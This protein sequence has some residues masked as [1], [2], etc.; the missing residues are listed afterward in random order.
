MQPP[1]EPLDKRFAFENQKRAERA[2]KG[3]DAQTNRTTCPTTTGAGVSQQRIGAANSNPESE[4]AED[5]GK[6]A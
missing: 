5:T 6:A 1:Q 3:S 4:E 2:K